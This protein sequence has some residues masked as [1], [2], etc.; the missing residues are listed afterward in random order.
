MPHNPAAVV[1][2]R[3][4]KI[5]TLWALGMNHR[6][7][8]EALMKQNIPGA[9]IKQVRQD[10]ALLIKKR[11]IQMPKLLRE[12]IHKTEVMYESAIQKLWNFYLHTEDEHL[13][14]K[15]LVDITKILGQR[16][17]VWVKLGWIKAPEQ[18]IE[19]KI[20]LNQV[21]QQFRIVAVNA[22]QSNDT[23]G[24]GSDGGT[25]VQS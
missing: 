16:I 18:A 10:I 24:S 15:T 19:Q 7:I 4:E 3:R 13:K 5:T 6:Q 14:Q 2:D 20:T 17:D 23:G 25:M 9:S 11:E 12:T 22:G 1:D 8:T 21:L